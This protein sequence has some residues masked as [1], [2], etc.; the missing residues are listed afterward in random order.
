MIDQIIKFPVTV[1][2]WGPKLIFKFLVKCMTAHGT[3]L[4]RQCHKDRTLTKIYQSIESGVKWENGGGGGGGVT[5]V[6]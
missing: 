1:N 6:T 3:Q 2:S 4:H 5:S